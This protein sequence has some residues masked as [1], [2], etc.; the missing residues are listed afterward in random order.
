MA[1]SRANDKMSSPVPE[2]D[3]YSSVGEESSEADIPLPANDD[4]DDEEDEEEGGEVLSSSVAT[5]EED[6]ES[7]TSEAEEDKYSEKDPSQKVT[8]TSKVR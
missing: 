3:E 5:S 1:N 2:L 6:E 8:K 4:D 7:Q